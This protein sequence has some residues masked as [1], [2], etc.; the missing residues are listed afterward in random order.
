MA[1]VT[2]ELLDWTRGGTRVSVCFSL[3][4][5]F[6][7][8]TGASLRGKCVSSHCAGLDSFCF[9]VVRARRE[10]RDCRRAASVWLLYSIL[11]DRTPVGR[12]VARDSESGEYARVYETAFGASAPRRVALRQTERGVDPRQ[13]QRV[14]FGCSNRAV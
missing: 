10:S 2:R 3:R 14:W 13:V 7:Q 5:T 9:A 4:A 11:A 8:N 1:F 12:E 6:R